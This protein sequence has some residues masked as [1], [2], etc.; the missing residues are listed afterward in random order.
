[1]TPSVMVAVIALAFTAVGVQYYRHR[2]RMVDIRALATKL[3]F[4]YIGTTLPRS[5]SL[6][7]TKLEFCSSVWNVIDGEPHGVR[8]I[9]FDCQIGQGKGS[10]RRTVVAVQ[11]SAGRFD[12][13]VFNPEMIAEYAGGWTFYYQPKVFSFIPPGLMPIT[14]LESYLT[15]MKS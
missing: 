10:W 15:A 3:G 1:M 5:L 8:V 6:E 11:S 7:G 4:S 14:E 12:P 13:T 9:G 2:R